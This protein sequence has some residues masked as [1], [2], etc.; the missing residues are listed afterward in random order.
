SANSGIGRPAICWLERGP[1][2]RTSASCGCSDCDRLGGARVIA[3][4]ARAFGFDHRMFH[5]DG[6][7]D[8]SI[9]AGILVIAK[10]ISHGRGGGGKYWTYQFNRQFGRFLGTD[11]VGNG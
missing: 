9:L 7:G 5:G 4:Y 10:L 1:Y 2:E 8:K 3:A 6:G 11:R